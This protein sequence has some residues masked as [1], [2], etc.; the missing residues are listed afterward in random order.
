[1]ADRKV[2]NTTIR[3]SRQTRDALTG[4]GKKGETYEEI[5]KRLID[6]AKT[7]R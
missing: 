6:A 1:M 5:I 3:I 2:G 7:A 4:I